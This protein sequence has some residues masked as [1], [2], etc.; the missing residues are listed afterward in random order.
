[1]RKHLR[2]TMKSSTRNTITAGVGT[3]AFAAVFAAAALPASAATYKGR[4]TSYSPGLNACGTVDS[5][6][7]FIVAVSPQMFDNGS[8]CFATV[9]ITYKGRTATAKVT[10]RAPGAGINDLDMSPGLFKY[11]AGQ[12]QNAISGVSWHFKDSKP[13]PGGTSKAPTPKPTM[14]PKPPTPNPT[15]T[16]KAPNPNPTRTTKAPNPTRTTKAPAPNPTR[17]P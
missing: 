9:S 6:G 17:T 16:T 2:G 3:L 10:D 4:A 15:R 11:F 14:T 1:M 5:A 12:S 8:V 7:D 13:T